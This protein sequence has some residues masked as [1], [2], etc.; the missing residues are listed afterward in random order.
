[1]LLE[2]VAADGPCAVLA[3][4]AGGYLPGPFYDAQWYATPGCETLGMVVPFDACEWCF[5]LFKRGNDGRYV[6]LVTGTGHESRVQ[7]ALAMQA[8][9]ALS[10]EPR[11][12]L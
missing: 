4:Q 12:P 6:R 1:M 3:Q 5:A 9:H 2:R 10:V 7:A 11:C 8:A